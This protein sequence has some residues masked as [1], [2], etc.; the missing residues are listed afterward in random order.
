[1]S[2]CAARKALGR[3]SRRQQHMSRSSRCSTPLRRCT[4]CGRTWWSSGNEHAP[5]RVSGHRSARQAH[6]SRSSDCSSRSPARTASSRTL[7]VARRR[8]GPRA[9]AREELRR[10]QTLT[11][12]T[13]FLAE[14]AR[15]ARLPPS[16]RPAERRR[17]HPSSMPLRPR[18][19]EWGQEDPG[20]QRE[21]YRERS[22]RRRYRAH[23]LRAPAMRCSR[24]EWLAQRRWADPPTRPELRPRHRPVRP[25]ARELPASTT[26]AVRPDDESVACLAAKQGA[27]PAGFSFLPEADAPR[28]AAAGALARLLRARRAAA[29]PLMPDP[30]ARPDRLE[31][32]PFRGANLPHP[33]LAAHW[34]RGNLARC[35]SGHADPLP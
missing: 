14:P 10:R 9:L 26:H 24:A 2:R 3:S 23:H 12:L 6:T 27:C 22:L 7:P 32:S 19:G 33:C 18:R 21:P 34:A 8:A 1:V 35:R 4:C 20:Q 25:P 5:R 31:A 28:R 15:L 29:S 30:S 17:R 16:A 13:A 11:A